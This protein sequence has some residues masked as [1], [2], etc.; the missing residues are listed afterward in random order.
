M[1]QTLVSNEAELYSSPL[2]Y[3]REFEN[4][5]HKKNKHGPCRRWGHTSVIIDNKMYIYG[6]TGH[7]SHSKNWECAYQLELDS[8]DWTKI[9]SSN[10]PPIS[11][12][13]HSC[14][15]LD[16]KMYIFGGSDGNDSKNDMYE[17]DM[18]TNTWKKIEAQGNLPTPREGHSACLI[19]N[20]YIVIYGGWNGENT[21]DDCYVFDTHNLIWKY[22]D[23]KFG[24][25]PIPRESQSCCMLRDHMYVFGGQGINIV[26]NGRTYENFFNDLY[27]FKIVFEDNKVHAVWE[28]I[29]SNGKKPSKRS[30]HSSCAYKNKYMF[31]VGGEGY[32]DDYGEAGSR[33]EWN[34]SNNNNNN[35]KN[36]VINDDNPPCFPKNDVWSYNIESN[37]WVQLKISNEKEFIP[38]FAHSC[39]I[40]EDSLIIFGGLSDYAHSTKDICVLSLNGFDP[41]DRSIYK[42]KNQINHV[43]PITQETKRFCNNCKNKISVSGIAKTKDSSIL[44]EE[45]SKFDKGIHDHG[46]LKIST[47]FLNSM[48]NLI[49]WPFASFG[50][51]IDNS[52][53][54]QAKKINIQY[55]IKNKSIY[56]KFTAHD[57]I[58]I[59]ERDKENIKDEFAYIQIQDNGFGWSSDE[60]IDILYTYDED[61]NSNIHINNEIDDS[62]IE[63]GENSQKSSDTKSYDKKNNLSK[64]ALNF[65]LAG[66]RLSKS[67][68][69]ASKKNDIISISLI[70]INKKFNPDI[71]SDH[72]YYTS[73]NY[74]TKEF[75]TN[76]GQKNKL[77]IF[78]MLSHLFDE[79]DILSKLGVNAAD[80]E[81]INIQNDDNSYSNLILLF[82]LHMI[83]SGIA[84]NGSRNIDY[85]IFFKKNAYDIRCSDLI[86]RTVDKPI[87]RF[88]FKAQPHKNLIELSLK[89]YLQ[90]LFLDHMRNDLKIIFNE[91]EIK[92]KSLKTS[93]KNA[94]STSKIIIDEGDL[95][96]GVI[97]KNSQRQTKSHIE[98]II[99]S[100]TSKINSITLGQKAKVSGTSID[101]LTDK[102]LGLIY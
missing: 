75:K 101:K 19:E 62:K 2:W 70:T 1:D 84:P 47:S 61:D 44:A 86:F 6:G 43:K 76:F 39:N 79:D 78:N 92:M 56:R 41:F 80:D 100:W 25:E 18:I 12:D 46:A 3:I 69:F 89:T 50:L 42:R 82:D 10:K 83:T 37:E 20:R 22:I 32:A 30:S 55:L 53:I 93:L 51:F 74:K 81:P 38:R 11:R 21:F 98:G 4:K 5:S 31:I 34:Q 36:N 14:T 16:K 57:D 88:A 87:A 28:K 17:C 90:Y 91:D 72:I 85:E 48:A 64:Y 59:P 7:T 26:A 96:D 15:V 94:N 77:I 99:T 29:E 65:K 95:Y 102:K 24:N 68:L 8:W 35:N 52:L 27:R 71:H 97:F 67:I 9:V 23:K 63:M 33:E 54:V 58:K 66:L 73:W 40:F 45:E 13:S 49:S 60:F